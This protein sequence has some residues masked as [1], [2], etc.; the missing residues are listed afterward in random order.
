M[1]R[2]KRTSIKVPAKGRLRE[3]ADQLWS[4]AVK[5]DWGHK[6][7]ICGNGGDL[8][9]HHLI[10]RHH[11]GTRYDLNNGICLCRRCHQFC[12]DHSPHQNAAGFVSWL[13]YHHDWLAEWLF[14]TIETG[15]QRFNDTKSASYYCEWIVTLGEYVE[16]DDFVRIVGK[17]FS[18]WLRENYES[19]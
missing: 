3:M 17:Q 2:R 12:P 1:K 15:G 13:E 14:Q 7:A 10:P 6:C 16:E 5:Y 19:E 18:E 8:N 4:L 11:Y 9:S